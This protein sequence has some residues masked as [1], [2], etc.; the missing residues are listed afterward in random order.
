[1]TFLVACTRLYNPLCPSVGLS[2]CLSVRPS[3]TLC[4]LLLLP[5]RTWLRLVYTALLTYIYQY[6]GGLI[7]AYNMSNKN[8]IKHK[9]KDTWWC[10]TGFST[11]STA[12]NLQQSSNIL[13]RWCYLRALTIFGYMYIKPLHKHIH[14]YKLTH[15]DNSLTDSFIH[16][17]TH[18][19]THSFTHSLTYSFTHNYLHNQRYW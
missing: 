15:T 9:F 4:F 2:V 18:L 3:V 16:S 6:I 14:I 19:L 11:C 10:R 17:L 7:Q 5:T 1:M 12:T 13:S 8:S